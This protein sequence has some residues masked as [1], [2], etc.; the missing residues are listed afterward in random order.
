M[1]ADQQLTRHPTLDAIERAGV[2]GHVSGFGAQCKLL[3]P[4]L[5][6]SGMGGREVTRRSQAAPSVP[7]SPCA[8]PRL[9][10]NPDRAQSSRRPAP[11][12][13]AHG[14]FFGRLR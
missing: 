13:A 8:S 7:G 1:L 5:R 12:V 9:D 11:L 14:H 2:E 3:E 4:N 6:R 10:M